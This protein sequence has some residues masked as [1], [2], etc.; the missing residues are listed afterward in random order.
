MP[1]PAWENDRDVLN[2][3]VDVPEHVVRRAFVD[4]SV[5]LNLRTSQYYGLNVTA[6][7][8]LEEL[9]HASVVKDAVGPLASELDQPPG[10]IERSLITLCRDLAARGLIE[11]R[12]AEAG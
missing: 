5:A 11:L 6:A 12:H 10:V 9:A 2:A 1:A 3:N 4:Q 7:R 8:M